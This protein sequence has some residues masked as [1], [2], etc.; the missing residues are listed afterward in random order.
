L[1]KGVEKEKNNASSKL[2]YTNKCKKEVSKLIGGFGKAIEDAGE[3]ILIDFL[4]K[5][6]FNNNN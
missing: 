1:L 5:A 2:Q 6:L 3:D 4:A